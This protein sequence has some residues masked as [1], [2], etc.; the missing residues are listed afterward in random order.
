MLISPFLTW[1][2][3][4]NP[5][6][7]QSGTKCVDAD[8]GL[9]YFK[10]DFGYEFGILFPGEG[11]KYVAASSNY[12]TPISKQFLHNSAGAIDIPVSHEQT[13]RQNL[14]KQRN[15]NKNDVYD[16]M[17]M[18]NRR[19]LCGTKAPT[20]RFNIDEFH[21]NSPR[22][23]QHLPRKGAF[24]LFIYCWFNSWQLFDSFYWCCLL[25]LWFGYCILFASTLWAWGKN[26][27]LFWFACF[28]TYMNFFSRKYRRIFSKK[29]SNS[30]C[31]Y[32]K[33][34]Q[35]EVTLRC[36]SLLHTACVKLF[37]VVIF[38][39]LFL[40]FVIQILCL[41]RCSRDFQLIH[42]HFTLRH[43]IFLKH[44]NEKLGSYSDTHDNG[45]WFSLT[46]TTA[47]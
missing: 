10:Y 44:S 8:T 28:D 14:W 21:E 23:K 6:C 46:L 19:K 39:C 7:H 31:M 36:W 12:S 9:I 38:V 25:R 11:R 42:I 16:F 40:T 15:K 47:Y 29:H 37:A 22:M 32:L 24:I 35:K 34:A 45:I 30:N 43:F 5:Y 20:I 3:S 13:I 33:N 4:I 27:M 1:I 18:K 41:F 26:Q 17:H 2:N